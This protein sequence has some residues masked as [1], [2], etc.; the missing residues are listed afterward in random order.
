MQVYRRPG[1]RAALRGPEGAYTYLD[2]HCALGPRR[3]GQEDLKVLSED[4]R[5]DHAG[6]VRTEKG[7]PVAG[8]HTGKTG[9]THAGEHP[10]GDR[11]FAEQEQVLR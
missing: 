8:K 6:A 3:A 10:A 5:G 9:Q 7:A 11:H 4:R 2:L 1:A